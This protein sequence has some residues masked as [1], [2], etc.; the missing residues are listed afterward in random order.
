MNGKKY[1][2]QEALRLASNYLHKNELKIAKDIYKSILSSDS[3]NIIALY[4]LGLIHCRLADYQ[5]SINYY[6]KVITLN[7]ERIEEVYLGLSIVYNN[8]DDTEKEVFSLQ[9]AIQKNPKYFVAFNNLGNLNRRLKNYK[10]AIFNYQEAI[11]IKKDYALA[12]NNLGIVWQILGDKMKSIDSY[13]KAVSYEPSNLEYEYNLSNLDDKNL[14]SNLNHKASN[15]IKENQND[16]KNLAFG[17]FLLSKFENKKKNY[18]DEFKYLI[19]GHQFYFNSNKEQFSKDLNFYFNDFPKINEKIKSNFN[20]KNL[21]IDCKIRPIFIIGLPRC[22]S[23]LVEQVIASGF[24][25]I[26]VG[27]ETGIISCEIRNYIHKAKTIQID[28]NSL[29][30]KIIKKYKT[31][32]L[33]QKKNNFIFTDKSLENFLYIDFLKIIFPNAKIINCLRNPLSSLVSTLKNNLPFLAWSHNLD[34]IFKYYDFYYETINR[35]KDCNSDLIYN[36]N[37]EK[38]TKD[39][40]M[41]SKKL[42]EYCELDWDSKC[43]EFYKRDDLTSQTVSNLQIRKAIDNSTNSKY[44][45]YKRF[46]SEFQK[47][48]S[49][50]C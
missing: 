30:N 50:F 4:N 43:L 32:K 11:K 20:K 27:E 35:T 8:L 47:K 31:F 25:A 12:H 49:W 23:T 45:I 16:F 37:Y 34:N 46:F 42:F 39:P 19:E 2:I 6:K 41:E 14:N 28:I 26:P 33:I 21:G 15:I 18:E 17:N 7:P 36:L 3:S 5:S 10:D 29:K 22:G 24:K 48:Y 9:K 13:K 44:L 38:F 1:S 40:L